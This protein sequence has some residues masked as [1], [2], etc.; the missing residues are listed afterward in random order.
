MGFA[1][2]PEDSRFMRG[3]N[4]RQAVAK[5]VRVSRCNCKRGVSIAA[6][7]DRIVW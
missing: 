2:G 6:G 3:W 5:R 1:L 7:R 4:G